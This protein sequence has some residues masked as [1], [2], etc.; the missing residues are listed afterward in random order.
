MIKMM[1]L[2]INKIK[3]NPFVLQSINTM[4]LRLFG[5]I[6]LFG[7]TLFLTHNYDPLI[8]G[9]YDFI[10]T[11]LLVIGS[12]CI[13]GT[14][15]SILYFTGILK[16][17]G[18]LSKLKDIYKKMLKLIFVISVILFIIF[19]LVGERR[20]SAFFN[21]NH[22][23]KI[24]LKATS[25]L[26]FYSVT[27][28]NTEVFRALESVYIAELFRNTFKFL[29]VII[30]SIVLFK[31]NQESYLVD[32][33]LIGFIILSII[34][35]FMIFRFLRNDIYSEKDN[36]KE[37]L[38]STNYILRKSYPMATSTLAIFLLMSFDVFFIKKYNGDAEIAFYAIAV[39]LMTILL[40]IMNSVTITVSTK[41]SEYF[42]GDDMESLKK[43]MRHS[44][45][46]IF[47]ISL[48][49]VFFICFF[50]EKILFFFGESY[51]KAKTALIILIIGQ[52]ICSFFGAV[53]VYLNMT[54]R[55]NVFQTI[56]IITVIL[57]FILNS[58]LVPKYGMT[59]GAISY[60]LSVFFWNLIA[61]IVIYKKDKIA[62]FLT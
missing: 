18:E 15:Q 6:V 46:L 38:I 49:I 23:F 13:I 57:N 4:A 60:T 35:T 10:R 34:S 20:I 26:F 47:T 14:D 36:V 11:Y 61:T 28:F 29:S 58:I 17:K 59:G 51:I 45:R 12:V 9:Q 19:M 55:Q 30:G 54:G 2:T 42:S 16:S 5:I 62:V 56:L 31:I 33:F 52:G 25:I 50:S 24:L 53:Q 22:S 43:T 3:A 1:L 40:M 32:T 44:A 7:F 41:I 8:I 21:D 39:K 37:E 27:F 48:P